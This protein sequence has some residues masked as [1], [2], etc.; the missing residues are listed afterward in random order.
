MSVEGD[1]KK[2]TNGWKAPALVRE[3]GQ[4]KKAQELFQEEAAVLAGY[5]YL[6]QTQSTES[7]H[8]HL[9]RDILTGGLTI[10][11]GKGSSKAKTIVTY[12]N[13]A[14][15]P[16]GRAAAAE[17]AAGMDADRAAAA[18][19]AR[20]SAIEGLKG[21][22]DLRDRGVISEGDYEKKRKDLLKRI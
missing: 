2:A 14:L 10:L 13:A 5:N 15:T 17:H 18:T 16:A 8:V 4:D 1:L 9:G 22:A 7:S 21:L 19:V 11:L 6:P 12:Q 20:T 3:Y